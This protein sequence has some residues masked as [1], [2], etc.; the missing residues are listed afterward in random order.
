MEK[1]PRFSEHVR[2]FFAL[3][4]PNTVCKLH[5][6]GKWTLKGLQGRRTLCDNTDGELDKSLNLED[7]KWKLVSQVC[8]GG[9]ITNESWQQIETKHSGEMFA[10]GHRTP[11]WLMLYGHHSDDTQEEHQLITVGNRATEAKE[12]D[13]GLRDHSTVGLQTQSAY[14]SWTDRYGL[15]I[16]VQHHQ[17]ELLFSAGQLLNLALIEIMW[18]W[19]KLVL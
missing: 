3:N 2:M 1:T 12:E 11:A 4:F 7:R 18:V 6:F 10:A 16:K 13:S 14:W 15:Y 19:E 9:G 17:S 5:L 8:R